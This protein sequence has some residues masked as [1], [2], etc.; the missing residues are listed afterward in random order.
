MTVIVVLVQA[1]VTKGLSRQKNL[2]LPSCYLMPRTSA[3]R[4]VL[5]EDLLYGSYMRLTDWRRVVL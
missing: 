2:L 1:D 5:A 4:R 3:K